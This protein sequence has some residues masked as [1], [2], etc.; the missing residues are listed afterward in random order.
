MLVSDTPVTS[1]ATRIA[2][3]LAVELQAAAD[4][5][6]FGLIVQDVTPLD[7]QGLMR[8]LALSK[9]VREKKLRVSLIGYP[10]VIKDVVDGRP[11]LAE[12]FA[13]EEEAA[14][15]W[16]NLQ[17]RTTAVITDRPL[18]KAASLR[19]FR[20]I[21][22]RNLARRLCEEQR[23]KAEV[24][25][26]RSL[27][28]AL[29]R[30]TGV[31]LVLENIVRF[32][33]QLDALPA[34]DRS[35]AHKK[36]GK[37]AIISGGGSGHEPLHLGFVGEGMLD[38]A[39]PGQIFTSPTPDQMVAAADAADAGAG[40]L[41]IVKNYEGDTMNFAMAAEL[42]DGRAVTLITDDDVA[43]EK[44]SFSIGRRGVAGTLVVEKIVGAAA[45]R[46]DDVT[47]LLVLGERV[48]AATRTMG[49]ALTSCTVPAAGQPTLELGADEME[50]GVGIHGEP[51]R[52]RTAL[53]IGGRHRRRSRRGDRR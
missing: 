21:N 29:D 32:A 30:S 10:D 26:L 44:S 24:N 33:E 45:E 49:V 35:R 48:N 39:C 1:A 11:V 25:W 52:R 42:L 17:L 31:G 18:E 4:N 41:F 6:E 43:V 40:I 22:D 46:G 28:D 3:L 34:A 15:G 12:S 9:A 47:T 27:W 14:V 53:Q 37:V 5:N 16:R 19:E 20:V 8:N 38:A 13:A 36:P 23:D 51:G 2:G 7:R 50:M